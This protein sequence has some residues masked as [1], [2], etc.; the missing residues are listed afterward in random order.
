M[1][2]ANTVSSNPG[3]PAADRCRSR[4]LPSAELQKIADAA[5]DDFVGNLDDLA[6]A[7]G[8]LFLG[9]RMGYMPVRL[10]WSRRRLNRFEEIL[11]KP[12]EQLFV[13]RTEEA[14]RCRGVQWADAFDSW[15]EVL[16]KPEHR[17]WKAT[18]A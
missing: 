16:A 6:E 3:V 10:I 17:K 7:L 11:G 15:W 4:P 5:V 14:K 9:H 12:L 13:F 1:N 18:S 2:M 8:V